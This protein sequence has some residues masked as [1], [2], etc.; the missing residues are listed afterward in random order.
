M[1]PR[2]RTVHVLS[3][4]RYE[5][6][7][8]MRDAWDALAAAH[9]ERLVVRHSLTA[10]PEGWTGLTGRGDVAMAQAALPKPTGDGST[11]VLVCGTDG[12][13]ATWG[14]PVG[15]APKKP[16]GSKGGKIQGPLTGLLAEA[17]FDASEV[18]KY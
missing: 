15:R 18:F 14:G 4:N 1:I 6:D 2:N 9:P 10:P 16:D 8:L 13:V 7:I 11:M 3:V 5:E 17:G 12:F